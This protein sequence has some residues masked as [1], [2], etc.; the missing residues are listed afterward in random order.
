[1]TNY[2]ERNQ[3]LFWDAAAGEFEKRV[4]KQTDDARYGPFGFEP[5]ENQ[6]NLLGDLRGKKI[7][8]LGFGTGRA[9][10]AFAK[11]GAEVFAIDISGRQ[12]RIAQANAANENVSITFAQ[13]SFNDLSLFKEGEFDAAFSSYALQYADNISHV[14]GQ[15]ARVLKAGGRFAFSLDHPDFLN[16]NLDTGRKEHRPY[17]QL[18]IDVPWFPIG[19]LPIMRHR[20]ED[21]EGSLKINGFN[22]LDRMHISVWEVSEI[23]KAKMLFAGLQ[24]PAEILT[25]SIFQAEKP[26]VLQ[27]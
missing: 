6:L 10:I 14:F 11:A 3:E 8:V 9:A 27:V 12:V 22:V 24:R 25:T 18:E 19:T 2:M 15:V 26:T 21:I 7:L 17:G 13:R 4:S 5:G 20:T 16:I 1:M 23:L